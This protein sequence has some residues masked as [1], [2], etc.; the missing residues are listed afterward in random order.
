MK[1]ISSIFTR[2]LCALC[3]LVALC[4]LP[5]GASA[6]DSYR[7]GYISVPGFFT[8][9]ASGHYR[10][11]G[12]EYLEQLATYAGCQFE[13]VD[14]TRTDTTTALLS[15]DVDLLIGS[16]VA[17]SD[18]RF[19]FSEHSIGRTP[20]QISL[21]DGVGPETASPLA[22]GYYAGAYREAFI[23]R[24][25]ARF[26]PPD[27]YRL[28]PYQER[29]SINA[30]L[31]SG[32]LQG[33]VNDAL[34]PP[35]GA[36]VT[37]NLRMV[38]HYIL[39]RPDSLA[40]KQHLDDA[41]NDM[42]TVTPFLAYRLTNQQEQHGAPLFLTPDEKA[43]LAAHPHITAFASPKQPPYAYFEGG[44]HKGVTQ[45]ITDQIEQDLGITFDIIETANNEEMFRRFDA[46][47]ADVLLDYY[48]DFNWAHE[49]HAR[50]T[51]PYLTV[52]YLL[53]HRRGKSVP[54]SPVIAAPRSRNFTRQYVER[55]YPA[56][57]IR[58]YD[59][60]AD[61][62]QAVADGHAD[63][64]AVKSIIAQALIYKNGLFLLDVENAVVFTQGTSIAVSE[65]VDPIFVRILNKEIAHLDPTMIQ[66]VINQETRAMADQAPVTS[67]LY[68]YPAE[69]V[70]ALAL[71]FLVLLS[72]GLFFL[73]TRRSHLAE[74]ARLAYTEPIT[75]L[76]NERWF[77]KAL[78]A[79]IT[80]L[81]STRA[82]GCLYLAAICVRQMDYYRST[83]SREILANSFVGEIQR[84]SAA[85]PWFDI[86]AISGDRAR[87]FILWALPAG[88]TPQAAAETI[89]QGAAV[90]PFGE[91][92]TRIRYH[93]CALRI[94]PHGPLNVPNLMNTVTTSLAT[95]R[96]QN[97]PFILFDEAMRE[98][99]SWTSRVEAAAP[100]AL[101]EQQFE[102]WYQPKYD[103][104]TH[105]L[106]GAE[107]LVRWQSPELGFLPPG[108]F[109]ELFEKNGFAVRL[110]YYMLGH[111]A[112]FLEARLRK[113]LPVIPVSVNQS[114]LHI[115]E[116]NY[117]QKMKETAEAY[118]LPRDLIDLEITETA[119]VDFKT[120]EARE[121]SRHIIDALKSY[122]YGTSMDDFCTGYSS[123]AMLQNLPMDTMKID[124]SILL[125]AEHD[126]R[127]ALIIKN[128]VQLGRDLGMKILCE[129]IE[130]EA[131]ENL[132]KELGCTY[133][134]GYFYAKPMNQK[135]FEAFMEMH[136]K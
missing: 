68:R 71:L 131:Q 10:G 59:T 33:V 13:Y 110:D 31:A 120:K 25:L 121:N 56:R 54:A 57:D 88:L 15:G 73:R 65:R 128:V 62:L 97:Q 44:H 93:V 90:L 112:R 27:R 84:A 47:E 24:Q 11:S 92:M 8:Q 111:V 79:A 1:S 2:L 29:Q 22:I 98:Q 81:E 41:A 130:T 46:G 72:A 86:Y 129:G 3:C 14:L 36:T 28:Q 60:D 82:A 85:T 49:H 17:P 38:T 123:I 96:T 126:E 113:G 87:L 119:F 53:V 106:V 74:I 67:M 103:L 101:A 95:A 64:A 48:C 133:G 18:S 4:F 75:G 51:N 9:D 132:L 77:E 66:T 136:L 43:W 35:V 12:Y 109:I 104:A 26:F 6:A 125:A 42:L 16:T 61:C 32:A 115:S 91:V 117:L 7:V 39:Y 70:G 55:T 100:R 78:P 69:S 5:S 122:G 76:H 40:L 30:D 80:R 83:Y 118:G 89:T 20:L 99:L 37:G 102:V 114:A 23:D 58:Y 21:A 105:A 107:A 127:S 108:R 124:R 116:R 52:N 34:H 63:I 50:I 94:A 19:L 45:D 135:D 134:Q